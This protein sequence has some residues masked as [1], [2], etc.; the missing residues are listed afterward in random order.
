[1]RD[2]RLRWALEGWTQRSGQPLLSESHERGNAASCTEITAGLQRLVASSHLS[3][4]LGEGG[5]DRAAYKRQ[6]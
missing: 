4:N 3:S 2:V 5:R 1:M 6:L